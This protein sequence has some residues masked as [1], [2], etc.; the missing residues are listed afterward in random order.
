MFFLQITYHHM[1]S[2]FEYLNVYVLPSDY[3]LSQSLF[4]F[5]IAYVLLSNYITSHDVICKSISWCFHLSVL[6]R[7]LIWISNYASLTLY[8]IPWCGSLRSLT[9]LVLFQLASHEGKSVEGPVIESAVQHQDLRQQLGALVWPH[10]EALRAGP[11]AGT[12]SARL[13][14]A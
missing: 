2:S 11:A 6:S 7:V 12:F 13:G 14:Y 9:A 5:L 8:M 3:T 4:E 1:A 10:V